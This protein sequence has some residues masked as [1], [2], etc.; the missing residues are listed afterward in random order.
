MIMSSAYRTALAEERE[1]GK[2]QRDFAPK[3]AIRFVSKLIIFQNGI[4]KIRYGTG[5]N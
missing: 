3:N 5:E 1:R 2:K 4:S